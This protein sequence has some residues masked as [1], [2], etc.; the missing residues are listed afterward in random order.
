MLFIVIDNQNILCP[1]SE[2]KVIF[3][4]AQHHKINIDIIRGFLAV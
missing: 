4:Q 3:F 1:D 2:S